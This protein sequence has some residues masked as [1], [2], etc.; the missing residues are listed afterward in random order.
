MFA[1]RMIDADCGHGHHC[2]STLCLLGPTGPV[3]ALLSPSGS[4]SERA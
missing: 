3:G 4:G 1:E 2:T